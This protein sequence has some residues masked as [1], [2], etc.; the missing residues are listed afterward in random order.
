MAGTKKKASVA[1]YTIK[2]TCCGAEKIAERN[3]YKSNSIKYKGLP[4]GRMGVCKD[5]ILSIYD[6]YLEKNN[7]DS[8]TAIYLLCRKLDVVYVENVY[9]ASLNESNNK[10]T[11]IY[12]IYMK[13]INSLNQYSSYTFDESDDFYEKKIVVSEEVIDERD[14]N[15]NHKQ[16]EEDV[17]RIL[18]YDPFESE[19][20]NDKSYLYN[21]LI[22]FLDESTLDD[23]FKLPAVIEIVKTFNQID[24]I[25]SALAVITSDIKAVTNN[26]GGIKSLMDAKK[27]MLG[28]VLA[29]AKD[30]GISVNH[31]NNRSKGGNTLNGIV[32]KLNEIGLSSAEINLFD[33]ETCDAMKQI[34]DFSNKSILENLMLD[35]NEYTDMIAQQNTMIKKLDA[36]LMK[37][38]EDYR[39]LKVQMH[40]TEINDKD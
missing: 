39:L 20:P 6:Y 1:K 29:L 40:L 24:K 10:G 36:E 11:H 27:Q 26:V 5:C 21:R 4:D 9:N 7:G 34:A 28:A 8:R 18:G 2:C 23:S 13:N 17:L 22:D 37:S 12:S 3:Y 25:N 16:N 19:N 15:L 33:L 14:V 31:N 30:N 32:K 38:K 35:E